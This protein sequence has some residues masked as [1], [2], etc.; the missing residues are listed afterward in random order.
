MVEDTYYFISQ[1]P[2]PLPLTKVF[3]LA[4]ELLLQIQTGRSQGAA[5]Y[6]NLDSE[7]T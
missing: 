6:S 7:A 3:P 4:E 5:G 2:S 1:L